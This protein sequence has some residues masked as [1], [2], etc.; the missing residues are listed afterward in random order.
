MES[1]WTLS[2]SFTYHLDLT[3]LDLAWRRMDANRRRLIRRAAQRGL[4]VREVHEP[5]SMLVEHL[6][7]LHA[8]Q[9][10]SYGAAVDLEAAAWPLAVSMLLS[11]AAARLFVVDDPSGQVVGFGLVTSS[12]PT[13][14]MMLSGAD[15]SRLDDGAAALLRWEMVVRLATDGV[16]ELDLNGARTGPHGRF[17]ASFGGELVE[18]WELSPPPAA[19]WQSLPR[20]LARHLRNEVR[21]TRSHH[22]GARTENIRSR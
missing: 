19:T 21:A 13:A 12:I 7:R 1:G 10:A 22:D 9:Q 16:N 8:E 20:R 2:A 14:A 3:D 18:R 15:L 17:K 5:S 6:A 11:S 4:G